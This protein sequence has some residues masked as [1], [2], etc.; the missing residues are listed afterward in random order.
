MLCPFS[1]A[2]CRDCPQFRGRHYFLCFQAKYRGYLGD[3]E[4]TFLPRPW[5]TDPQPRFEMPS[6]LP[7]SPKWLAFN[8]YVER[9]RK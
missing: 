8:E 7:S 6:P 2:L 5:Q 9:E 1:N 3:S 4:K